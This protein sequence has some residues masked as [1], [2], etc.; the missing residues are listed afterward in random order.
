MKRFGLLLWLVVLA[1]GS[2]WAATGFEYEF[3]DHT[4]GL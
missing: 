2:V 4:L 1:S 3:D